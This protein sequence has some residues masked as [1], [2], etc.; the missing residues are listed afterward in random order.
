MYCVSGVLYTQSSF[1]FSNTFY[2]SQG[3]EVHGIAEWV[4]T[5]GR[6]A[7]EDGEV[8]AVSGHGQFVPNMPYS[9]EVYAR[10]PA[11]DA[12]KAW[13]KVGLISLLMY[14]YIALLTAGSGLWLFCTFTI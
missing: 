7:V 9:A 10:V 5:R 8:K 11:R 6:I 3:M 13:Q 14:W 2:H 1:I 4:L 12:A